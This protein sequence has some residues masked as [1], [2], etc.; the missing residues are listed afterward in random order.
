MGYDGHTIYRVY[1][2]DQ[3]KVIRV[4]DLRI[5]QDYVTKSSTRLADYNKGNPTFQ[6]F[7]LA[8]NDNKQHGEKM[9]SAHASDQEVL[10][11]EK[12]THASGQKVLDVEK[13]K[14]LPLEKE[15]YS[16]RASGWKVLD[17]DI[18]KQ[19]SPPRKRSQ[20][21]DDAEIIP[22][23]VTT[24]YTGRIIKLSAKARVAKRS[25]GQKPDAKEQNPEIKNPIV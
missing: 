4:K 19:S 17:V 11:V 18:A 25:S 1:L 7:L 10:K 13:V 20:K 15:M 2:K 3:K 8:N 21:V 6:G 24:S 16:T 23:E 9:H 12:P 5:F 22:L 14:H